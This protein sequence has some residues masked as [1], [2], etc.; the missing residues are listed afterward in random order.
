METKMRTQNILPI[1]LLLLGSMTAT[2]VLA[3]D[4]KFYKFGEFSSVINKA[5]EER[6]KQSGRNQSLACDAK[7]SQVQA[8]SAR[9]GAWRMNLASV[10]DIEASWYAVGSTRPVMSYKAPF[11]VENYGDRMTFTFLSQAVTDEA[12]PEVEKQIKGRRE[13]MTKEYKDTQVQLIRANGAYA[14]IAQTDFSKGMDS[15]DVADRIVWLTGHAQ[16]L[17]CDI[18]NGQ[19]LYRM[20]MWDRLKGAKLTALNKAEFYT[21]NP[22][23]HEGY[24]EVD[25]DG[26]EGN[27]GAFYDPHKIWAENYGDKMVL[28][29]AVPHKEADSGETKDKAMAA[30][31]KWAGKNKFEDAESMQLLW[32][33][34]WV[35]IGAHYPY[36]GLTGKEVMNL[37]KDFV[38]DYA[39]D[40][41]EDVADEL[42]DFDL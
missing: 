18:T 33:N 42:D 25:G 8:K 23:L 41:A 19:E 12:V 26:K 3:A 28:W 34:K 38:N 16:F 35:W 2:T 24:K 5:C 20:G 21:L 9:Q 13:E 29:I 36:K 7:S 1:A 31:E 37:V 22:I 15:D 30:L 14:I 17:M 27:W 6:W 32:N 11:L 10:C 4:P 40:A 39:R